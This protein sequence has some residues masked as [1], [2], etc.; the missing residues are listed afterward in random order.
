MTATKGRVSRWDQRTA[1]GCAE[2][3]G[4]GMDT[5]HCPGHTRKEQLAVDPLG[6]KAAPSTLLGGTSSRKA[7]PCCMSSL[8]VCWLNKS[9]DE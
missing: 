4:T 6:T 1:G 7:S 2:G 5:P 3:L 9:S 8:M